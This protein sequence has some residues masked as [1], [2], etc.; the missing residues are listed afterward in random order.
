[1]LIACEP[2]VV[3]SAGVH[4]VDARVQVEP[5]ELN[6]DNI[7]PGMTATQSVTI[8]SVGTDTM[9]LQ[10]VATLMSP[11]FTLQGAP[12]TVPL[13]PGTVVTVDV[14]YTPTEFEHE[15][16]LSVRTDDPDKRE[17]LVSLWGGIT[18]PELVIEPE[19]LDHGNALP[20][21]VEVLTLE[22]S[23]IGGA[24]M[25]IDDLAL[26]ID[27]PFT[28]GDRWQTGQLDG[29]ETLFADLVYSPTELVPD[30]VYEG[31]VLVSHDM[32]DPVEVPIRAT[33]QNTPIAVCVANPDTIHAWVDTANFEGDASYNPEGGDIIAYEWELLSRPAGSAQDLPTPLNQANLIDFRPDLAGDYVAQLV[34]TNEMGVQSEPCEATLEATVGDDLWIELFWDHED[35]DMDI[36]LLKSGGSLFTNDDCHWDNCQ[37]SPLQWGSPSNPDDN[38]SLD[39]DDIFGTGPENINIARP[40]A[41]DYEIWVHDFDASAFHGDNHVTVNIYSFGQ[42]E[43]T[44]T[45]TISGEDT[46]T[47]FATVTFPGGTVTTAP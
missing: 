21:E 12:G 42:L 36:H 31:Y 43:Y 26:V 33:A 29:G 18:P 44:Q 11:A 22:M 20:G 16:W 28:L 8:T 30:F 45:R 17:V 2:T 47:H 34:V 25:Q 39:F 40:A 4:V 9:L 24:P 1:M 35:D 37:Y 14:V 38:P 15:G 27:G 23:N 32:G 7:I 13:T 6:Y 10:D 19:E 5:S 46:R 41:G 3:D